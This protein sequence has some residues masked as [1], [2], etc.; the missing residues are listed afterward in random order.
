MSNTYFVTGGTGFIGRHLV[1]HLLENREGDIYVLVRPGSEE[2][3]EQLAD[4]WGVS[5]DGKTMVWFE[6]DR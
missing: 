6:I 1:E 4:R 5:R 2:R 3:L